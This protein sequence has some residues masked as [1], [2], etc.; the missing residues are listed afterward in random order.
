M[1]KPR[2]V[3]VTGTDTG[4]GKTVISS[5]L[6][7]SL[8]KFTSLQYYKPIQT[9]YL[10]DDDTLTVA[11]RAELTPQEIIEPAYRLIAP[12]SPNRAAVL[13]NVD[14]SLENVLSKLN[15]PHFLVV[16]GAG[17]LEVP[18]RE[19]TRMS[20]L[21]KAMDL[22][23][24]VVASTRLGT[25]NHTLLTCQRARL[26]GITVLGV[27]LSG[28][29]D[30]GLREV[31]EEQGERVLF[32]IP[33]LESEKD[34]LAAEAIV[35][36]NKDLF[37]EFPWEDLRAKDKEMIWHPFTQHNIV[38]DH[39]V[40]TRAQGA[41]FYFENG[42]KVLDGISS[43]WVNVVGHSHPV[44]ALAIAQQAHSLE[45]VIFAGFTHKPAVQVS[46]N[47]LGELQTRYDYLKKVFFSDNGST[48]VE[49]ALKMAFQYASLKGEHQRTKFMALRGSY[50]GD[51]LG[52]MSVGEPDGFHTYFKPLMM[53]VDYL[54]PDNFMELE[55][56][57]KT[58]R[59]YAA[60]IVEPLIQGAGGMRIYSSEYLEKLARI[61]KDNG[62]LLIC[63]EIFT[64]FY[65][66]GTFL[67]SY[68][69][70]IQPDLICL[71]KGL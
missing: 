50:H 60:C 1:K 47:V 39:T 64:G 59:N 18:I 2:G 6:A 22:P 37:F 42:K 27:I 51:T 8:K 36:E 29:E 57:A 9:G 11:R 40:I 52:A 63:D 61:C 53:P 68:Q 14:I 48:A 7:K 35:D 28:P 4:V 34:W 66:T 70:Q 41:H 56:F 69:T 26:Q 30:V 16:E 23:L 67:A 38:S 44:V 62:V 3:F 58:A 33:F 31:L 10:E 21:V 55:E 12:Q 32:S 5:L 19:Q 43:W 20:D 24:V 17:G 49:V 15:T 46:E 54:N 13:E 45:H 25:I 65:R 71:S